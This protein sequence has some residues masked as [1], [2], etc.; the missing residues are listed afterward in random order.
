GT[1]L[2]DLYLLW[3][4]EVKG[5]PALG[6]RDPALAQEVTAQRYDV[7]EEGRLPLRARHLTGE[8]GAAAREPVPGGAPYVTFVQTGGAL[9][10]SPPA[11][12]VRIPFSPPLSDPDG[13]VAP[14]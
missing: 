8:A 9:G 13:I 11:P 14:S 1:A 10:L 3:P 2:P 7:V 6:A 12:W 4:G 5:D